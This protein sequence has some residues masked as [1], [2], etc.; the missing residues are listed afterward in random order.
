VNVPVPVLALTGSEELTDPNFRDHPAAYAEAQN[1]KN[2]LTAEI[3]PDGDHY[4]T[5]AQSFAVDRLL[6]WADG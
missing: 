1:I 6:A 2:D 5:R 3:V 4:Y